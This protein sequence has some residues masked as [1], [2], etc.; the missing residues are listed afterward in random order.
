MY[1]SPH[2]ST[3]YTVGKTTSYGLQRQISSSDQWLLTPQ[4]LQSWRHTQV[5]SW[6]AFTNRF[7]WSS[8]YHGPWVWPC[9]AWYSQPNHGKLIT[10]FTMVGRHQILCLTWRLCS[11]LRQRKNTLGPPGKEF[12]P[13][14]SRTVV[15]RPNWARSHSPRM[16]S[17]M[18]VG[19]HKI[20]ELKL[21]GVCANVAGKSGKN[22]DVFLRLNS[23][24]LGA[25]QKINRS[26]CGTQG[27]SMSP[28]G[29][30]SRKKNATHTWNGT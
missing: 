28:F 12:S 1:N 11:P 15:D 20:Q 6:S 24:H 13:W 9:L 7:A 25:W 26:K 19:S 16:C 17:V 8:W 10:V 23:E 22:S 2:P 30:L 29:H 21:F 5:S 4:S 18:D 14:E 27:G 3:W